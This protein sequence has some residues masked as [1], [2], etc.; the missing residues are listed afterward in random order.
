MLRLGIPTIW[1]E[2]W[3]K[4]IN[5]TEG[6][7]KQL[8][9]T[10]A[11][12]AHLLKRI[13]EVEATPQR[14]AW[15]ILWTNVFLILSGARAA[16]E[17]KSGY[18]L[19]LLSRTVIETRL[20]L[21]SI[22]EPFLM[23]DQYS[24]QEAKRETNIRMAAYSAWCLWNDV[25]VYERMLKCKHMDAVWDDTLEQKMASSQKD[26]ETYEALFGPL[27]IEDPLRLKEERIKQEKNIR[28]SMQ[29]VKSY[30]KHQELK[31]W[32]DKL[33]LRSRDRKWA[34]S[35]FDLLDMSKASIVHGFKAMDADFAYVLYQKKS[36]ILHGSTVDE[37]FLWK[38]EILYPNLFGSRSSIESLA[39]EI[40]SNCNTMGVVLYTLQR[41]LW[42]DTAI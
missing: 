7:D 20:H 24:E 32:F 41:D 34:R 1:E 31:P 14:L 37:M 17:H 16:L 19:E 10:Q 25:Q 38:D 12:M 28:E 13:Q 27:E 15:M 18:T 21:Q 9:T 33:E 39:E 30:L 5:E 6:A 42:A 22:I 35:F 26:R 4:I 2:D 23:S 8:L 3:K 36:M 40:G 11:K 29:R